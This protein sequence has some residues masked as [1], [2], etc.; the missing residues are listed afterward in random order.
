M[1]DGLRAEFFLTGAG[2]LAVPYSLQTDQFLF[3]SAKT[4]VKF[5]L[6]KVW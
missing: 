3:K 6:G 1:T 5:M 2:V 4:K